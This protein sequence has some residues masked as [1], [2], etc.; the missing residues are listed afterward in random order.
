MVS[1]TYD[2][3]GPLAPGGD[4]SGVTME[5]VER[6]LSSFRGR[7]RQR[8]P[9]YSA[10]HS[11]GE[12]LYRLARRGEHVE[13]PER[14]AEVHELRAL[15]LEDGD[16]RTLELEIVC[17]TGTYVR[18]LA[19]DI[20]Q[21]LGCGAYLLELRRTSYGPLKADDS[22]SVAVFEALDSQSARARLLPPDEF[23]RDLPAVALGVE[24]HARMLHGNAVAIEDR[25][26]PGA[27]VRAYW[28]GHLVAIARVSHARM[29]E[30][31]KVFPEGGAA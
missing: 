4:P 20:G 27:S 23:V 9:A 22:I 3:E 21:A 1:A 8:P 13:P 2:A 24:Q 7:I 16:E 18:S 5:E 10:L 14:D 26:L 11:G 12:R 29:L 25:L 28:Q 15:S 17:A 31:V 30:P 6:V 19:H